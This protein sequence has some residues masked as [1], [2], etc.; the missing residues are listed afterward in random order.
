MTEPDMATTLKGIL[1]RTAQAHHAATGGTNPQWAEWYAEHMVE[2][3]NR[4]QD[5]Q[6]T[7]ADLAAWLTAAD[8]RYRADEQ[9]VSWPHAYA[10]W[11]L[12]DG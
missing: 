3:L 6:W 5:H 1:V 2:E 8:E 7:I 4:A 12:E 9:D 11:M 10:D